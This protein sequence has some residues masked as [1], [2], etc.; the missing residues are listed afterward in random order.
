ME[1]PPVARADL[2]ATYISALNLTAVAVV[3]DGRRCRIITGEPA[4]G[5]TI[6]ARFYFKA[7][8]AELVLAEI[9][10]DGLSGKPAAVAALIE[11]TARRIGAPFQTPDE[12]HRAAEVQV[13]AVQARVA[14]M[15]QSGGLSALNKAYRQYRLGQVAR[16]ERAI[17]YSAFV[18][19]RIATILRDVAMSGRAV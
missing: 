7:S 8:H 4:P 10:K 17:P 1:S 12:L 15:N 18:E 6:A 3:A 2:I 9:D 14:S 13:A 19:R 5:E 11:G 16:A